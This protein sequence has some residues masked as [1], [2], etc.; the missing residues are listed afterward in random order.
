M[1]RASRSDIRC[2]SSTI[3]LGIVS[4]MMSLTWVSRLAVSFDIALESND[5]FLA[6]SEVLYSGWNRSEMGELSC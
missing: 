2:S 5:F 1:T 4:E 6:V 3:S